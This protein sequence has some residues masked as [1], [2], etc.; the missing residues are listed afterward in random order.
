VFGTDGFIAPELL[1]GGLPEPRND[2]Y[3]V[4]ALMYL[5][6]TAQSRAGPERGAGADGDA[7]AAG[8]RAGVAAERRRHRHAGAQRRGGPVP[9]AEE[10]AAAIR[11]ALT[12]DSATSSTTLRVSPGR[13][14]RARHPTPARGWHEVSESLAA[15][16]PVFVSAGRR[17]L[18][19]GIRHGPTA[20]R[21]WTVA[22]PRPPAAPEP[23]AAAAVA[24]A[25]RWE[26][27]T[28]SSRWTIA[29]ADAGQRGARRRAVGIADQR[30]TRRRIRPSTG[31]AAADRSRSESRRGSPRRTAPRRLPR[32]V[33]G[34]QAPE[35]Q[36]VRPP[37]LARRLRPR[38]AR[39]RRKDRAPA[40]P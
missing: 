16:T 15:S 39:C 28:P 21:R 13:R 29:A 19:V 10:M 5:M 3:S 14:P 11:A 30:T 32:A 25:Q 22:P 20:P 34:P 18:G 9:S 2:L 35:R 36:A 27:T 7:V 37:S 24:D 8:L 26:P 31:I 12:E 17:D 4:G 38:R 1:G 33:D 23:A 6:L 40:R